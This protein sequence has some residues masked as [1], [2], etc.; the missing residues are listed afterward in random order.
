MWD[1]D[2]DY[3]DFDD[4]DDDDDFEDDL[5]FEI[6]HE[7]DD[8]ILVSHDTHRY[9]LFN[10]LTSDDGYSV[11]VYIDGCYEFV[12]DGFDSFKS[13][14]RAGQRYLKKNKI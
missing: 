7:D 4:Y 10:H 11:E 12:G 6:E 5:D 2:L 13:A 14:Y 9:G 3:D 1:D 8:D